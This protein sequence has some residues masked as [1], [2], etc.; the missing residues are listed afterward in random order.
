MYCLFLHIFIRCV[1]CNHQ[2]CLFHVYPRSDAHVEWVAQV[3][4]GASR[5]AL[6]NATEKG[7]LGESCVQL[8]SC[9]E[10]VWTVLMQPHALI[11]ALITLAEP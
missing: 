5:V 11:H 9:P 10:G 7:R 4:P 1:L 6:L 2:H 8:Y 3:S